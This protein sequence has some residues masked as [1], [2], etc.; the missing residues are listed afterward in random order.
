[1][2]YEKFLPIGTVVMLKNG[3]KRL[4]ITGFCIAEDKERQKVFDYCGCVYPEGI[5]KSNQ[6]FLFDHS[7]IEKIYYMGLIDEEEKKFKSKLS[8]LFSLNTKNN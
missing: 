8:D 5:I 4:M 7:Q 1:M 3:K 2:N 6:T